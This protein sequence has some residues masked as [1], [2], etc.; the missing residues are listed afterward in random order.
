MTRKE[1]QR[2]MRRLKSDPEWRYKQG[3]YTC[4]Q[5]DRYFGK[6][7]VGQYSELLSPGRFPYILAYDMETDPATG[8]F[9]KARYYRANAILM[10]EQTVLAFEMYKEW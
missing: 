3:P 6:I 2:R 8:R 7:A 10:F 9:D 1:F 4:N 5:V